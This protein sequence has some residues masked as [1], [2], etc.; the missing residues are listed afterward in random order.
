MYDI[1]PVCDGFDVPTEAGVLHFG[2]EPS[3]ESVAALVVSL[4]APVVPSVSVE[5][6]DG[7]V[8]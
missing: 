3:Q 5:A 4:T 1:R 8:L 7:E 6:E 2:D